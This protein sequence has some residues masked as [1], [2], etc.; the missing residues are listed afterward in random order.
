MPGEIRWGADNRHA[1]VGTDAHGDH[2]FGDLLTQPNTSVEA[3]RH[4][5]SQAVVDDDFD[6]EIGIVGQ[7]LR[8]YRLQDRN[9]GMLTGRYTQ[10]ACGLVAEF[11][12]QCQLDVD[13][14]EP[15]GDHFQQVFARFRGGYAARGARQ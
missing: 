9:R 12:E 8:E 4:N 11:A 14:F 10:F 5:V 7:Q 2:V 1:H 15:W 6:I 13:L 3:F